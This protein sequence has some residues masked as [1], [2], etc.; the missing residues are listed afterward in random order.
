MTGWMSQP[1]PKN[2]AIYGGSSSQI[3]GSLFQVVSWWKIQQIC[4]T[5]VKP[6]RF[7]RYPPVMPGFP[8]HG[9]LSSGQIIEFHMMEVS[10]P[11]VPRGSSIYIPSGKLT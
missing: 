6:S 4:E 8:S 10:N 7:R 3:L 1:I 9:G 2:L 5:S 11:W